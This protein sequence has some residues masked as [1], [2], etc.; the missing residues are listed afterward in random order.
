M[1]ESVNP[2]GYRYGMEPHNINPFWGNG[3][4]GGVTG[5]K[6]AEETEY[7]QGNVNL[8]ATDI[9]AVGNGLEYSEGDDSLNVTELT[10]SEVVSLIS[11]L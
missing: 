4:G 9:M 2:Q 11:L 7:R 10:T 6:G 5:V 3:G 1:N 8:K